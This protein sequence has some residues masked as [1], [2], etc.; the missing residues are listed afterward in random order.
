M[1]LCVEDRGAG[2]PSE[3]RSRIFAPGF[4]TRDAANG[5]GLTF[6]EAVVLHHGG[7][8]T[9]RSTLGR[10]ASFR[11]LLPAVAQTTG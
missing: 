11:V 1:A 3:L 10:G 5:I 8:I 7:S 4:T 6:C 2:I 9:V